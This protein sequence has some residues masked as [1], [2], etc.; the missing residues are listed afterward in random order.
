MRTPQGFECRYFY[1]DYRRGRNK[2]ECRL[3]EGPNAQQWT[4]KLCKTCPVPGIL[5][6]NACPNLVL[7]AEIASMPLGLMKRVKVSAFCKL[8]GQVVKEPHIGCGECH[9]LPPVFTQDHNDTHAA[10]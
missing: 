7:Q 2:E 10:S 9:P 5:Q 3:V 1:G 6:A 4:S 8:S